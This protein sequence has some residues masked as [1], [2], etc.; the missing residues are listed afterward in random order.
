MSNIG[1][2]MKGKGALKEAE[3]WWLKAVRLRPTYWD[4]IVSLNLS[5]VYSI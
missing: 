2:A 5:C 3:T 1:M 4:A